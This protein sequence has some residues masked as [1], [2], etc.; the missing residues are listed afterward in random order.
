MGMRASDTAEPA[1]NDVRVP[2]ANLVGKAG[3]GFYELMYF[4]NHTRLHIY[5]QAAGLAPLWKS[6]SGMPSS[7]SNTVHP[8][9]L[10]R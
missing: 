9:P 6:P 10:S 8:W 5:A 7:A 3:E 2:A 4:F 1:L